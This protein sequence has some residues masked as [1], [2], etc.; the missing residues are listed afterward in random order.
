MALDDLDRKLAQAA[1]KANLI[2]AAR[3]GELS[4]R[5]DANRRTLART[6]L[7]EVTASG[8]SRDPV[9]AILR[10]LHAGFPAHEEDSLD[11]HED[12]L[13]ARLALRVNAL[14]DATA[15]AAVAEQDARRG[16]QRF[17]RLGEI[18]VE[19]QKIDPSTAERLYRQFEN[20]A[21]VCQYCF[22]PN[23]RNRLPEGAPLECPRC[24]ATAPVPP[25][26]QKPGWTTIDEHGAASDVIYA[27][28]NAVVA[29]A[30]VETEAGD[31]V[32]PP[33]SP[34]GRN[35]QLATQKRRRPNLAPAK[36]A[37]RLVAGLAVGGVAFL[38]V[39]II[40]VWKLA[41][42]GEAQLRH[43]K[44]QEVVKL[45]RDKKV[46][47]AIEEAA[48][49]YG[50]ALDLWKDV[51][52]PK[53]AEAAVAQARAEQE[54]CAD[55]AKRA[56]RMA[57]DGD[58]K[59]LCELARSCED[60]DVL[61]ALV[62]RL[63]RSKDGVAAAG[64]V[65]L[66]ECKDDEVRRVATRAALAKGGVPALPL[67]EKLVE[68]DGDPLQQEALVALLRIADKAALP[69][70]QKAL[71]R[72]P[73]ADGLWLSA[74]QVVSTIKDPAA[75]PL[76]KKLARDP[77]AQVAEAAI[78]GLAR[79]A[80][81]EA[82]AEL[83]AGLD[84][85]EPVSTSCSEQLR[86]MGDGAIGPLAA[87]LGTGQTSAAAPL[88]AIASPRATAAV[89]EALPRLPWEKRGA[90][91]ELLCNGST[92]AGWLA[93]TV[94]A[95]VQ[96]ARDGLQKK[97]AKLTRT[98][99]QQVV[100]AA[101]SFGFPEAAQEIKLELRFI[102]LADRSPLPI[103]E[104]NLDISEQDDPA[105][106]PRLELHNYTEVRLVLYARG[107]ESVEL[108]A[109]S[110]T[111]SGRVLA[112]GKYDVWVAR[113]ATDGREVDP[114]RGTL[115]LV[116]G[117]VT[118][119][120]YGAKPD[121]EET[122]RRTLAGRQKTDAPTTPDESEA[123][124]LK[125][126][127]DRGFRAEQLVE[128]ARKV[129]A[130]RLKTESPWPRAQEASEK[131]PHYKVTSDAG[132]AAAKKVAAEL[133]KA[134]AAYANILSV[135]ADVS[136]GGFVVRFFKQRSD[137][138]RWRAFTS[139]SSIATEQL[140]K[141]RKLPARTRA[142][143]EKGKGIDS[144]L[145]ARLVQVADVLEKAQGVDEVEVEYLEELDDELGLADKATD[146]KALGRSMQRAFFVV[147]GAQLLASLAGGGPHGT[148]PG[149]YNHASRELCLLETE[150]W[151][152]ALR[153]EAFHQLL[154]AHASKAPVWL[155]EGLATYFEAL[156]D[157]GKN[158]ERLGQLKKAQESST[159]LES[160]RL[161]SLLG[162]ERLSSLDHAIA[163]S[164]VY[165][166]VENEPQTLGKIL[167]RAREGKATT[168]GV[169]GAFDDMI[170]TEES[171]Q[172]LTRRLVLSGG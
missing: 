72:A 158:A 57:Q 77:R 70:I 165:Y 64:L 138:E 132:A 3:L 20:A 101:K 83:V 17:A 118:A 42:P 109:V 123:D 25:P 37:S 153:H 21:V 8:A 117:K 58:A 43:G 133:E 104:K 156:D 97:D 141:D 60:H 170:K 140:A 98:V 99:L 35:K 62:E 68:R 146:P 16:R 126:I 129:L 87:A 155:H 71:E 1:A 171:W 168:F 169:V 23:A 18:L 130:E 122:T 106:G 67:I 157:K 127:F 39:G 154:S 54:L 159:V 108:H 134:H 103:D 167:A 105:A 128:E 66:S 164:F 135:P 166:L 152:R 119:I 24:G 51:K 73:K 111:E 10:T 96:E 53:E 82:V 45:A 59:P 27:Q 113:I 28:A 55:F 90:V 50:S 160:L 65:A 7:D 15:R 34:S 120:E 125:R 91:L 147:H 80:P 63:A 172:K 41:Q 100:L 116:A 95:I 5:A 14:D 163:W 2:A 151:E 6:I 112:A 61:S 47:G 46:G 93:S 107:P 40:V 48:Q 33:R 145:A 102:E 52:P 29:A 75:V 36:K 12:R 44:F 9:L 114:A 89:T 56:A 11:R 124:K 92:P 121:P 74:A 19:Q 143:A 85:G 76:L 162:T 13:I 84:A 78:A 137:Y 86:K 79:L 4:Q 22:A 131:T 149:H 110:N 32:A 136:S 148:I 49:A 88:V 94:G 30:A 115:E 150:G 31:D 139:L 26:A 144:E 81:Q 161:S 38:F 142:L 69:A